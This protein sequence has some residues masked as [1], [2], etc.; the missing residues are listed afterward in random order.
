MC[1]INFNKKSFGC[2]LLIAIILVEI[3]LVLDIHSDFPNFMIP[4]KTSA[5]NYFYFSQSG[6]SKTMLV[7]Y[8]I[9]P[10]IYAYHYVEAKN[11]GFQNMMITRLNSQRRYFNR[12]LL[13][14][15]VYVAVTFCVLKS[16]QLVTCI[17]VINPLDFK[18]AIALKAKAPYVLST[19]PFI[20]LLLFFVLAI[21]G[22]IIFSLLVIMVGLYIEN[23]VLFLGSGLMLSLLGV[24]IPA[25]A[26][27]ALNLKS[28]ILMNSLSISTLISP[29]IST[30]GAYA[31]NYGALASYGLSVAFYMIL[32]IGLYF[33]WHLRFKEA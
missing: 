7:V 32:T 20:N 17:I 11:N 12:M 1:V 28:S 19:N 21:L 2:F 9:A 16:V 33:V 24:L 6:F 25:L 13:T 4:K 3:L 30:L 29:G 15:A 8:C 18:D 10:F 5:L 27:N 22:E 31:P 23:T 14:N 26:N